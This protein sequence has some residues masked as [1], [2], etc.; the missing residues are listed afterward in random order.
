[1]SPDC[2]CTCAPSCQPCFDRANTEHVDTAVSFRQ[3]KEAERIGYVRA[4]MFANAAAPGA[5]SNL[6]ANPRRPPP[7]RRKNEP[8]TEGVG[9]VLPTGGQTQKRYSI[10]TY[11]MRGQRLCPGGF[12]AFT[13]L[14]KRTLAVHH[15]QVAGSMLFTPYVSN[16]PGTKD[17]QRAHT[18]IALAFLDAFAAREADCCPTGRGSRRGA[19]LLL[20]PSHTKKKDVYDAY[21]EAYAGMAELEKA[22]QNPTAASPRATPLARKSFLDLWSKSRPNIRIQRTGSDF[23]DL[24]FRLKQE[25]PTNETAADGLTAHRLHYLEERDFYHFLRSN[26][27][28]ASVP[29]VHVTFDF[30]EKLLLPRLQ[31]Q[32]GQMYLLNGLH[33]DLFGVLISNIKTQFTFPLVEGHW[34]M[35]NDANVVCAM[36]H[37]T[38]SSERV[39]SL[40]GI[41]NLE[42]HADNCDGQNKNRWILWY[43][44]WRV[45]TQRNDSIRLHF[46]VAG[47]TK[48]HCDAH[49]SLIKRAVKSKDIWTPLDVEHAV[50]TSTKSS[51]ACVPGNMVDWRDW[52]GYLEG[53]FDGLVPSITTFAHFEFR[54]DIP[55]CVLVRH[56]P[57]GQP[58][59]Y[60][61]MKQGIDH[62]NLVPSAPIRQLDIKSLDACFIDK[63]KDLTRRQYLKRHIL[64]RYRHD[65]HDHM[66]SEFFGDAAE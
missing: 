40:P 4:I 3:L 61:L 63:K 46:M 6:V 27:K 30:A 49:F 41:R 62:S 45:A 2:K 23:C 38:L 17:S 53:F 9:G 31:K 16:K 42:L 65:D 43:L 25:A 28:E 39:K 60:T 35:A 12:S 22:N 47:H 66:A 26:T 21:K 64:E 5:E 11:T 15:A 8:A 13:Q 32:P 24:C 36:L 20:L 58:K 55:G 59:L 1:M 37:H 7:K 52:K 54:K 18:R 29:Y 50:A 14:S 44:A 10:M 19:P 34:P 51:S 33:V 48:N 56:R 57:T